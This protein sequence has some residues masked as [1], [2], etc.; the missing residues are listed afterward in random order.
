[1]TS[2]RRFHFSGEDRVHTQGL[3][4]DRKVLENAMRALL[5]ERAR[6]HEEGA[7]QNSQG[8]STMAVQ[9]RWRMQALPMLAAYG[10]AIAWKQDDSKKREMVAGLHPDSATSSMAVHIDGP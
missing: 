1:M 4:T 8:S 5:S 7:L 6:F 3:Q 9:R 10:K 2:D